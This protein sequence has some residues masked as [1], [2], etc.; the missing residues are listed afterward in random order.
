MLKKQMKGELTM[1]EKF[2]PIGR[3]GKLKDGQKRLMI[4]GFLLIEQKFLCDH[5]TLCLPADTPNCS[6]P[7]QNMLC[8]SS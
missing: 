8:I 4:T 6:V 3:V 5:C 7:V 1:E 2:L